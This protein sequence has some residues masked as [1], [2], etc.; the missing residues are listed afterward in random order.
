MADRLAGP[1][2][3]CRSYL[4]FLCCFISYRTYWILIF[5]DFLLLFP[6]S[7]NCQFPS[8][9]FLLASQFTLRASL[10]TCVF[11][12]SFFYRSF[13]S[14]YLGGPSFG[15]LISYCRLF[16]S[17]IPCSIQI[18]AFRLLVR[19][20][21]FFGLALSAFCLLGQINCHATMAGSSIRM[22]AVLVCSAAVPERWLACSLLYR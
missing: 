16:I 9:Y 18:V 19:C 6:I 14:C 11:L 10:C 20:F 3:C 22:R 7:S 12:S 17:Q 5:R 2:R 8:C 21:H 4:F 1:R 15:N 13:L